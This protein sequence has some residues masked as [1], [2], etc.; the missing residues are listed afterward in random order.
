MNV[1]GFTHLP[2][3]DELKVIRARLIDARK[4]M[5]ETVALFKTL[6]WPQFNAPPNTS[7]SA[8]PT[9]TRSLTARSP[10]PTGASITPTIIAR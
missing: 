9:S 3:V 2:T 5:D 6:P 1:G 8:S 10:P 4:D 7:R